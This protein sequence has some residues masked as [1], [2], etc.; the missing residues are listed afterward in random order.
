MPNKSDM[1]DQK[2]SDDRE[3]SEGKELYALDL[4]LDSDDEPN[5]DAIMREAVEA[6]DRR[7]RATG[8]GE[9]A[10]DPSEDPPV[11]ASDAERIAQLE[12]EAEEL[13]ERSLRTLADYENFRRRLAKERSEM[14][15][16]AEMEP[17][18]EM[19]PV[20][21]NLQRALGSAGSY[22][23]L[24]Q[25]VEL[26][27]RQML[28]VVSRFGVEPIATEGERF[29]PAV[30]EAVTREEDESVT[31]PTVTD[32]MQRG[33]LIGDR[34]LRPALVRVAVPAGEGAPGE[35]SSNGAED[36]GL[37]ALE[38]EAGS[39]SDDPGSDRSGE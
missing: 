10:E 2:T 19:L 15:R 9:G 1:V 21:D 8:E 31:V 12:A 36:G 30:H 34:L 11:P 7:K 16:Q 35:K 38:S 37:E 18:R 13:K 4:D 23:D 17:L 39:E 3:E 25:G 32:E 22:E 26:I 24:K 6:I 28:D 29:D 5:A 20:I 33:Y 14:R 27:Q